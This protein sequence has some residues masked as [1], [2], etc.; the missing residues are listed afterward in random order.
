MNYYNQPQDKRGTEPANPWHLLLPFFAG[1]LF[2]LA[3]FL[4]SRY[5]LARPGQIVGRPDKFTEAWNLINQYYVDTV[6]QD[7]LMQNALTGMLQG[8][9]PHSVYANAVDNKKE[10]ESLE[11]AFD[12]VGIQFNIMN[13]TIM[14][15]ATVSG[16]PSEK[17]GI[18]AG[19]RIVT[20]DK[21][22]VANIGINSDEVMKLLR[23]KRN[24]IVKVGIVRKGYK[25]VYQY[26]IKRD[27]IPTYSIDIAYMAAPQ[28]GYVKINQFGGTTAHEFADVLQ[29]LTQKG[30]KKLILDLRGNP[31]GYLD[32][33]IQVCDE[34]LASGNMIVYTEGMRMKSDPVFATNYG[35]FE[36]GELVVLIDDFSASASEIVAGAVQDNDRGTI[37]GR[38]SFG[39]GLVQRQFELPDM[40]TIRLTTA[41]Y[42]TPSG[43]CIQRDY[44]QGTDAYYQEVVRRYEHGE[45]D[46]ADSIKPDKSLEYHTKKGRLVYGGGGVMPDIFVAMDR[47]SSINAFYYVANHSAIIEYAFN[48]TT[49]NSNQLRRQYP[50]EQAFIKGMVVSEEMYQKFMDFFYD[51]SHAKKVVIN[52][53][54]KA[55]IKLWLKALIG[56]N[57]YQEKAYFPIINSSDKVIL[58]ALE[59]LNQKSAI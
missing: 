8:L 21:K 50:N 56:R 58:K 55:E 19:D 42:H 47:D 48:Y 15:V 18:K 4:G 40:S 25:E 26:E 29:T 32:A 39:K 54:S 52:N 37:I 44:K 38:R 1:I 14:V 2:T 10:M 49:Q 41:R 31:G 53:P 51:K 59:T 3:V 45:M 27:V 46:N 24:S 28:I 33:A 20:V 57:L 7:Q 23:G 22:N 17:I 35:H 12:G 6:N 16:G 36:T 9:D 34:L 43:R 30:M 5:F 13:D 11:G